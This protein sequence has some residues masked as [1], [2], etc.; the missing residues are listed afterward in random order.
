MDVY[1]LASRYNYLRVQVSVPFGA[2]PICRTDEVRNGVFPDEEHSY[3]MKPEE[4]E[5]LAA[6]LAQGG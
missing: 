4:V 6:A 3:K 2:S 1:D 5:K